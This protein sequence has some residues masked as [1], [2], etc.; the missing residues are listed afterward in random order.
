MTPALLTPPVTLSSKLASVPHW[1]DESILTPLFGDELIARQRPAVHE[2][3]RQ[4]TTQRPFYRDAN[5]SWVISAHEPAC[6]LLADP[7][8]CAR[9]RLSSEQ[10]LTYAPILAM[11]LLQ[12]DE[13]HS[14][15]RRRF[16]SLFKAQQLERVHA[17]I[18]ADTARALAALPPRGGFE[19]IDSLAHRLPARAA[20]VLMGLPPQYAE[21]LV[22]LTAPV[23]RILSGTPMTPQAMRQLLQSS[24]EAVAK[25]ARLMAHQARTTL[26]YLDIDPQRL[27]TTD[28][29][30]PQAAAWASNLCLLFVAAYTTSMLSVGNSVA[31]ALATPGLWQ[32]L[33]DEPAA[34]ARATTELGRLE[35]AAQILQRYAT[36]DLILND[37]PLRE[38]DPV[39]VLVA[40]ANRDPRVYRDSER[41]DLD[42][43]APRALSFGAGP[44]ACLGLGLARWQ[45]GAVLGGLSQRYPRLALQ[46][47]PAVG[48]QIGTFVGYRSLW[49]NE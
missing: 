32:R 3:Y 27:R 36:T 47:R 41:V 19:L 5:G 43:N 14:L 6:T 22:A 34:V 15:I 33:R 23:L 21:W 2:L 44:H 39:V 12:D 38:G 9:P 35:P 1:S 28:D 40:A 37:Q 49:L 45:L 17:F 26:D 20:C 13:E 42:R 24:A 8:F 46:T 16:A 30:D 11:M 31:L 48:L 25:L 7:R 29:T 18:E 4:L 10:A